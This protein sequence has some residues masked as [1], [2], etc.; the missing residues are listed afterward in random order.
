[1]KTNLSPYYEFFLFRAIDFIFRAPR[2]LKGFPSPAIGNAYLVRK[3]VA[4]VSVCGARGVCRRLR[5]ISASLGLHPP[6]RA[7]MDQSS[8]TSSMCSATNSTYSILCVPRWQFFE[9]FVREGRASSGCSTKADGSSRRHSSLEIS[10]SRATT[11]SL[12]E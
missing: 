5:R 4:L 3:K 11:P 10:R 6:R 7:Q 9:C 1:M 2:E 12:T 8:I